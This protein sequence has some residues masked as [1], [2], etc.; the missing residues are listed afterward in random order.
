L[1]LRKYLEYGSGYVA[2]QSTIQTF[3]YQI[4]DMRLAIALAAFKISEKGGSENQVIL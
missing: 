1:L 3:A 2:E 4:T